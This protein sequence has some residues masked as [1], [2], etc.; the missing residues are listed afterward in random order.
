MTAH[1]QGGHPQIRGKRGGDPA[2]R[3][4]LPDL[5]G[6]REGGC[7]ERTVRLSLA[8]RAEDEAE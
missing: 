3:I 2:A 4:S 8:V 5:M 7:L 6:S 1:A